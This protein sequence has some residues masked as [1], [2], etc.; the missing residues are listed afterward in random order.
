M[1]HATLA[2]S[3]DDPLVIGALHLPDLSVN[4][5]LTLSQLEDFALTNAGAFIAGGMRRIMLQDQT[6]QSGPAVPETIAL[7]AAI[8]RSLK[9]AFPQMSLGIIVQAHDAEAPLA[10]ARASG[11][12]FVRLKVFVG[13]AMTFEGARDPLAVRAVTYRHHLRAGDIAIMADVF[14]RTSRP[15]IDVEPADAAVAAQKYGADALVLTGSSFADSVARVAA[16]RQAGV[17]RPILIGGSVDQG[18]IVQALAAADGAIVSTS[19]MSRQGGLSARWD[20]DLIA[21]LMDTL[22][23]RAPA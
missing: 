23:E 12:D 21:R 10:I 22:R 9:R 19:L 13:A 1:T 4:R 7:T 18:N 16:A 17:T 3:A 6:R 2:H 20:R 14:D 8:G 15:L 5:D 11:A